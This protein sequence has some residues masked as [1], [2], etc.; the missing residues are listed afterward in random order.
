MRRSRFSLENKQTLSQRKSFLYLCMLG[1]VLAV[2]FYTN[3]IFFSKSEASN[4]S[5]NFTN[6][7]HYT[8]D[9]AKIDI[10]GSKTQLRAIDQIDDNNTATGFGGATPYGVIWD[11]KASAMKIISTST[12]GF[13]KLDE[14]SWD[15]TA[16][17]VL[18]FSGNVNH[19][20]AL[21]GPKISTTTAY[22]G[23]SGFFD[24]KDDHIR[25]E[26]TASL[27]ADSNSISIEAWINPTTT[28][29][30]GYVV[31]KRTNASPY[32][33]WGML[34]GDGTLNYKAGKKLVCTFGSTDSG[35]NTFFHDVS[36]VSDVV[37]GQW[38]HIICRV[39][40]G[41]GIDIFVDGVKVNTKIIRNQGWNPLNTN[42]P[43]TIASGNGAFYYAGHIDEVALY[44][45]SLTDAEV[46][47]RYASGSAVQ[48]GSFQS[49]IIDAGSATSW[50]FLKM[51]HPAPYAKELPDNQRNALLL[52]FD[53][54]AGTTA[55]NDSSGNSLNGTCSANA[56]PVSGVS[57]QL[58]KALSFDG[59]DDTIN[60]SSSPTYNASG[61][62]DFSFS[63]WSSFSGTKVGEF[64]VV[65]GGGLSDNAGWSSYFYI[66]PNGSQYVYFELVDTGGYRISNV[67]I[68]SNQMYHIAGTYSTST[69]EMMF[70][71]NG[72]GYKGNPSGGALT[73]KTGNVFTVGKRS[74]FTP[75]YF[76]GT[77]DEFAIFN[78][79]L[80]AQEVK[81]I[82]VSQKQGQSFVNN[83]SDR[84]LE[85]G[86]YGSG[87]VNMTGNTLLLHFN[88][89]S[90]NGS[91]G[92]IIDG[93]GSENH[94][95][96]KGG[97]N[98]VSSGRF[99]RAGDFDG[100]D[101]SIDFSKSPTYG[102][103]INDFSFS[104]WINPS[105]T[106]AQNYVI[107]SA[108]LADKTG[109][110]SVYNYGEYNQ[111]SMSN[112]PFVQFEVKDSETGGDV[113]R[114]VF[115]TLVPNS[116]WHHIAGSYDVSDRQMY[117]YL[118]GVQ[119]SGIQTGGWISQTSGNVFTLGKR[120]TGDPFY[121][122]GGIDEFATF[123]R[124]ISQEEVLNMYKRGAQRILYQARSCND[125][126]CQGE[127]FLGPDGTTKTYYSDSL[128]SIPG[129]SYTGLSGLASN[130]YFQYQSFLE[131]DHSS[132][133]PS[134]NSVSLGFDHYYADGPTTTPS[135]TNAVS[136]A[137]LSDFSASE[138]GEGTVYYQITN[139]G[140][141]STPSWY[142]WNGS[143]WALTSNDTDYNTSSTIKTNI[144]QFASSLGA[145]N[146]LWKAILKVTSALKTVFLSSVS[147]TY[148]KPPTAPTILY[149][150]GSALSFDGVDDYI[151]IPNSSS[152]SF[153]SNDFSLALWVKT[154][155]VSDSGIPRMIVG[156]HNS[157]LAPTSKIGDRFGFA[158]SAYT[159][160]FWRIY[161]SGQTCAYTLDTDATLSDG[162]W[163]HYIFSK[164]STTPTCFVDGVQCTKSIIYANPA[165]EDTQC[166]N[167]TAD[168]GSLDNFVD[169]TLMKGANFAS[170]TL[171]EVIFFD[172][173]LDKTEAVALYNNGLGR[174]SA[175]GDTGFV[176]GWHF[177]E[178]AGNVLSDA[179]IHKNTGTIFGSPGWVASTIVESGGLIAAKPY[180]SAI[181]NDTG[182]D[183]PIKARLQVSTDQS[184]D[185]ISHWDSGEKGTELSASTTVGN[186]IADIGY[187][188]F[189]DNASPSSFALNDGAL[190]YYWRIKFWD[191]DGVEGSWS[192][193]STFS[194]LDVPSLPLSVSASRV[195]DSEFSIN[196]QDASTEEDGYRIER[197]DN[198]SGSFTAWAEIATSTP[199]S[200]SYTDKSTESD[201]QYQFRVKAFNLA[202]NSEPGTDPVTHSTTPDTPTNVSST[203]IS[204]NKFEISFENQARA[205]DIH[206]IE[207]CDDSVCDL[208]TPVYN[209][210]QSSPFNS[211]PQFDETLEPNHKYRWRVRAEA[212][213]E[214][215]TTILASAYAY[216][217][218][219]YTAPAAPQN[220]NAVLNKD[221]GNID[222]SWTDT[223]NVEDGFRIEVSP[224][225]GAFQE[226]TPAVNTVGQNQTSYSY[227]PQTNSS[228]IFRARSYNAATAKNKELYS[229]Y[230][231]QTAAIYTTPNPPNILSPIVLSPTQIQ[232][233]YTD[234]SLFKSGFSLFDENDTETASSTD[235]S[236]AS[237]VESGLTP[238][239]Q[240][241]RKVGVKSGNTISK[242]AATSTY[243]FANEP[244]NV[245]IGDTSLVSINLSWEPN[246]NPQGTE[247]MVENTTKQSNSG[248][249]SVLSY[250]E[251]E[252]ACS[253]TYVFQIRARNHDGIETLPRTVTASASQCTGG[254]S[255]DFAGSIP[256]PPGQSPNNTFVLVI[257][258]GE[259]YTNKPQVSLSLDGGPDAVTMA[260]SESPDFSEAS[261]IPYQ[262]SF[263]Y[264]F[265]KADG[266]KTLYTRFYTK[267]GV[268][269]PVISSQITLDTQSPQLKDV[270]AEDRYPAGKEVLVSGSIDSEGIIAPV[271]DGVSKVELN[272]GKETNWT[273]NLGTLV[274]GEYVLELKIRDRAGNY[275][276]SLLI[277]FEVLTEEKVKKEKIVFIDLPQKTD[278]ADVGIASPDLQDEVPKET[279][280]API[281][282]AVEKTI[283]KVRENIKRVVVPESSGPSV[284]GSL[285]EEPVALDKAGLFAGKQLAGF[286]FGSL[287]KPLSDLLSTF[288]SLER[289][290][291]EFGI[292]NIGD[293]H[294]LNGVRLA[295]PT[296]NDV[297][298][299]PN[300][301]MKLALTQDLKN[302]FSLPQIK[303]AAGRIPADVVFFGLSDGS[304]DIAPIVDGSGL[305]RLHPTIRTLSNKDLRLV[306]RPSTPVRNISAQLALKDLRE[307]TGGSRPL[308]QEKTIMGTLFD[309]VF[310]GASAASEETQD[311]ET[312]FV[313]EEIN[314]EDKNND[315]VYVANLQTPQVLGKYEIV[316]DID[317]LNP[318]SFK[319][320]LRN[321]M[322]VDPEGYVYHQTI[323]GEV[324]LANVEV[325]LHWYNPDTREFEL[326]PSKRYGQENPQIT[327]YSGRYAFLVPEGLYYLSA[328]ASAYK[329]FETHS[330][331][332]QLTGRSVHIDIGMQKYFDIAQF[333]NVDIVVAVILV[334]L[335]LYMLRRLY[336]G[337]RHTY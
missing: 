33:Q 90:W 200:S 108:G 105:G 325:T 57:G 82:Y 12:A 37:N 213:A 311:S 61:S 104:V 183:Y 125:N 207:R 140:D 46:I 313:L 127:T 102:G 95:T 129:F 148:N 155:S 297:L 1:T 98:T 299:G 23:S 234:N 176:A 66:H 154:K 227:I 64:Y 220:L 187:G 195:S 254:G 265:E 301:E 174:R 58:S 199:N 317:Y 324:R 190:S 2:G 123:N 75:K 121:Y 246:S 118:N 35:S 172:H 310:E 152:L 139:Q 178:G 215:E 111:P 51:S 39:N 279:T 149:A 287:P 158:L 288:P 20:A 185:T 163:H 115:H 40:Y 188:M 248:W 53:E 72:V 25:I 117:F 78:R 114:R 211:S 294:K 109:G 262:P 253:Q 256:T 202:G 86:L 206:G 112:L 328:E 336:K 217:N 242:S 34:I 30:V 278:S 16:K 110:W 146:F 54:T 268:G 245:A 103:G 331:S 128:Q 233:N 11:S 182:V 271:L 231:N 209:P 264:T 164:S 249:V 230:S 273:L 224:N 284:S 157:Y 134:L 44:K 181:Y 87:G 100:K 169:L 285:S 126:A 319:E 52:H 97:V 334:V 223:A 337:M 292:Q 179:G 307:P 63:Y 151:H 43:V 225:G 60:F 159:D 237:F 321:T 218:V 147:I 210:I 332:V 335:L 241:T 165:A 138:G 142:W 175:V 261:Q 184:F 291:T 259:L 56:C 205:T 191:Q 192:A 318:K 143:N 141:L 272:F 282:N 173:A 92:E 329:K 83:L 70:Y 194:M 21:K 239:T 22:L 19:G 73:Q 243:T 116:G 96:A 89:V 106:G 303:D 286:A 119:T 171:D 10:S 6:P 193:S 236:L 93:S 300:R 85:T 91:T 270:L 69:K 14:A 266:M 255:G 244:V 208:E 305:D 68:N 276:N 277:P 124:V 280:S 133:V 326:W 189:G 71:V 9:S 153:G 251:K 32:G 29:Q 156:K 50:D 229:G 130:R 283:A 161:V 222:L 99:S 309:T 113:G 31:S 274:E 219:E 26:D 136:Y 144:A 62:K 232:W 48:Y 168:I 135:S 17:E 145:G 247:Y 258:K 167:T 269:S 314:F 296:I 80:S 238:N 38:H 226:L 120:A 180:F 4:N 76:Q 312:R 323:V 263:S 77:I 203:Y 320:P 5:W 150:R 8:F 94:G 137:S 197:S 3:F 88:E 293:L 84:S 47:S 81:N 160:Q 45:R 122:K 101:D 308:P 316:T 132:Y 235:T 304:L 250:E 204:D 275:G 212:K 295:L 281:T 177:D 74:V 65:T 198:L 333:I 240:Y 42:E 79:K 327:N 67:K 252:L 257:N 196:W 216:S 162:N 15:G 302:G 41:T 306:L 221:S 214:G 290:F 170:G 59:V 228:Y 18:D 131:T 36:T 289:S 330:F 315:G 260:I 49:R 28:P 55:F 322:L 107:A 166:S 7:S 267:D 27:D 186:R 298:T 13:W 201:A 24:G